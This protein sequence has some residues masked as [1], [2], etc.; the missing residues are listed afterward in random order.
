MRFLI[1]ALFVFATTACSDADSEGWETDEQRPGTEE[2]LEETC[3]A[4]PACPV[5]SIEAPAGTVCDE[6]EECF[7]VSMCAR[8]N[9]C[10][11]EPEPQACEADFEPCP[12][13]MFPSFGE[14]CPVDAA[15][16][17][18]EVQNV[19]GDPTACYHDPQECLIDEDCPENQQCG[20]SCDDSCADTSCCDPPVCYDRIGP[21][22]CVE[23]VGEMVDAGTNCPEGTLEPAP[24]EF[25]ERDGQRCCLRDTCEWGGRGQCERTPTCEWKLADAPK[26]VNDGECVRR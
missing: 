16:D 9:T 17:C 1:F 12:Q 7:F 24:G 14:P 21:L 6:V 15:I 4:Y 8:M 5:G 2:I 20:Q 11:P 10:V 26:R 23:Q 19:C 22:A 13:E 3:D 18:T 25:V